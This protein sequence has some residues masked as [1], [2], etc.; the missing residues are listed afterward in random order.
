[1]TMIA[2]KAIANNTVGL[3]IAL[4]FKVSPDVIFG[5]HGSQFWIFG[6]PHSLPQIACPVRDMR[7]VRRTTSGEL[8]SVATTLEQAKAPIFRR[9]T[10]HL[11]TQTRATMRRNR[12]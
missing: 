7:R 2:I 6:V 12:C 9:Q 1:M 11:S 10:F 5:P 4:A 8:P 3:K